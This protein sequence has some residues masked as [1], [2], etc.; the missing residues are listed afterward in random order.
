MDVIII[1]AFILYTFQL[2]MA[3]L[4]L[5][6]GTV[7]DKRELFSLIVPGGLYFVLIRGGVM[8]IF[9]TLKEEYKK[10]K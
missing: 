7:I 9:K 8:E 10:L 5:L 1:V 2:G 6:S 3:F 4:M